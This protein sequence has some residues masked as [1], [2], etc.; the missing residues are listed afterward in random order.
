MGLGF[1]VLAACFDLLLG[2]LIYLWCWVMLDDWGG[3]VLC[4]SG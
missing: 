4:I 1:W 2:G 3:L